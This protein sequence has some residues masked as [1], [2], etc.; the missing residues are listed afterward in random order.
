MTA[1][2][3][4]CTTYCNRGHELATGIPVGHECFIL[5]P[6]ALRLERED[7]FEE[8]IRAIRK[9][10]PLRPHRGKKDV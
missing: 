10:E 3:I 9:A 8:S 1:P 7:K 2:K 4:Y 5:P 6:E